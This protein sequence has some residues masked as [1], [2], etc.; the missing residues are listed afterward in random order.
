MNETVQGCSLFMYNPQLAQTTLEI[1][2]A[3]F[4]TVF[5]FLVAEILMFCQGFSTNS[6]GFFCPIS[7]S[8]PFVTPCEKSHRVHNSLQSI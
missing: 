1:L 6:S 4:L 2:N 8:V 5:A 3:D 7:C